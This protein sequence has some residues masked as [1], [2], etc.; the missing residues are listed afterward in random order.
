MPITQPKR[1]NP[2]MRRYFRVIELAG[3]Q[4]AKKCGVFHPQIYMAR[5][6]NVG[7]DNAEKITRRMA[8]MLG[9]SESEH[10]EL[11]AEIMDYPGDQVRA[12]F[13][14]SKSAVKLLDVPEPTALELL[15]AEKSVT[16]KSGM[17]ALAK[18]RGIGAPQIVTL[19]VEMRLMP[20]SERPRGPIPTTCT[21]P[22]L[23]SRE[24]R[25]E[26]AY[27]S[28]S[29]RPMR[30]S[31]EAAPCSRKSGRGPVLAKGRAQCSPR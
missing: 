24:L 12:Y 20:P 14:S 21:L 1:D 6:R 15:N 7:A 25:G 27:R 2:L 16:H 29:G 22:K 13:G 9:L 28:A 19:S 23:S 8:R 30:C 26:T 5:T 10:L 4:L 17:R 3:K 11:K 31:R 18:L